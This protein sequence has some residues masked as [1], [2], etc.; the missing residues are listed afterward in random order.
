MFGDNEEEAGERSGEGGHGCV[1]F[2]EEDFV[3]QT[4]E[5]RAT[6]TSRFVLAALLANYPDLLSAILQS[7]QFKHVVKGA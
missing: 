1:E 6:H 5:V 7:K 4:S 2:R 3:G